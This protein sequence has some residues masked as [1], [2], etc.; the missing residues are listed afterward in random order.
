MT[1]AKI[2]LFKWYLGRREDAK[3]LEDREQVKG[4]SD[5]KEYE[6]YYKPGLFGV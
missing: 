5:G 2:E 6:E 1:P 4:R 3:G